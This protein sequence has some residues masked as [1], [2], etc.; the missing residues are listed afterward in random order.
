MVADE[1]GFLYPHVDEDACTDCGSCISVCPYVS[2]YIGGDLFPDTQVLAV[3]HKNETIRMESSSGGAFTAISDFIFKNNGVVYGAGYD[4]SMVVRHIRAD[5]SE[6]RNACR[7]SKYVQSNLGDIFLQVEQD[8]S[9]NKM[10]MFTGTPCQVAGLKNYIQRDDDNLVLVDIVC[11]GVP[12]PKVFKDFLDYISDKRTSD[13]K[14]FKF[15]DKNN[16]WHGY[17]LTLIM[18]DGNKVNNHI[19][20]L[21]Y[22]NL[23]SSI[24]LR[25]NCYEC[26]FANFN[27]PGDLTIGDFWGIEK[28]MP[29]FADDKG[30]SLVLINSK[31]GKRIIEAISDDIE[32]LSSTRDACMQRNL[33]AP[34]PAHPLMNHFWDDYH[35]KGYSYVA[36]KYGGEG[37]KFKIRRAVKYLIKD[38]PLYN[39]YS[40]IRRS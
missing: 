6:K 36:K 18:K 21:S 37:F 38:T 39:F 9:Q 11:H 10:V 34:S 26:K 5:T 24:M 3:K 8:L 1:K 23:F 27:R 12:S 17:N 16:G 4:E 29:S 22:I 40:R 13:I 20:H 15:R 19:S 33:Y 32:Y 14:D 30:V 2:D 28:T 31:K 25:P 7:G 35:E